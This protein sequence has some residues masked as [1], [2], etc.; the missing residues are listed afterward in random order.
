MES[1]KLINHEIEDLKKQLEIYNRMMD[2]EIS[3]SNEYWK[4]HDKH[5]QC[6]IKISCLMDLKKKIEE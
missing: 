1:I 5:E 3:Y 6:L 4:Y 2:N